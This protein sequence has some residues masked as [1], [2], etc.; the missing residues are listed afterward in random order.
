M[1]VS[2][3]DFL[4][5]CLGSAAALGLECSVLGTLEKVLATGGGPPIIWIAAANCTGCTVSLADRISTSEPSGAAEL[6]INTVNLAYHPNLMGAAGS[7]A[8]QNALDAENSGAFILAVEG[9]VPT[10]FGGRCCYVWR[11]NGQDMTA[12]E[13][14]QR[15]A[16]KAKAILSVGTCASFG[17]ISGGFPKSYRHPERS[18]SHWKI[19]HQHSRLPF[20]PGLDRGNDCAA[21]HRRHGESGCLREADGLLCCKHPQHLSEERATVG[22]CLRSRGALS[23]RQR[24]QGAK[25]LGRLRKSQMERRH[26]LVRG[27]KCSLYWVH[28]ERVSR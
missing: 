16:A 1:K 4:K 15:L 11:E 12:M 19:D 2:R 18:D 20:S 26:Q 6:L 7:L 21:P 28:R 27:C 17:G 14:V 5:Y 25:H 22:L 13:V 9:G 24:L 10:A 23:Q 3:R 8:V